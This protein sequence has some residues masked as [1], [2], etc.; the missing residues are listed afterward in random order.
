MSR[1]LA[2]LLAFAL[3]ALAMAAWT[4]H[5]AARDARSIAITPALHAALDAAL[6]T[7]RWLDEEVLVREAL[8]RGYALDD[9]I[10]RRQLQRRLRSALL[11][12][13]P[14]TPVDDAALAGWLAA[15]ADR[16]QAQPRWSFEQVYLSRATHGAALDAAAAAVGARLAASPDQTAALGDPFPQGRRYEQ[17]SS[18]QVEAAFGGPLLQRLAACAPNRWCGPVTTSLGAHWLRLHAA[19]PARTLT[20]DEARSHLRADLEHEQQQQQLRAGLDRLRAGWRL[21]D[22][23]AGLGIQPLPPAQ[24]HEHGETP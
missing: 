5:A 13:A 1:L 3:G 18:A 14:P 21:V 19:E 2:P 15:H 12:E 24:E 23:P 6:E 9:Q 4:R 20:L 22:D 11:A 17:V 7:G 8:A 10:V 16:Y